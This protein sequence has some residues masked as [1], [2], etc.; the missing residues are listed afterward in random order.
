MNDAELLSEFAEQN[1]QSAFRTLMER[2]LPLVYGTARRVLGN[3]A[4]AED[5]AQTVFL[6]LARKA[7]A[8]LKLTGWL[9]N[10]TRFV[11]ARALRG[12]LRRTR[13]EQQA[14]TMNDPE[15]TWQHVVPKLDDALASLNETDRS[16]I[17]FRFFEQRGLREV[18]EAL[19]V[20]E[21]AAKKRVARALERLRRILVRRG[22][23][24]SAGALVAG[25]TY[26]ASALSFELASNLTAATLAK[27]GTA[28]ATGL[29]AEILAAITWA[30][31]KL[32]G[33]AVLGVAVIGVLIPVVR[34]QIVSTEN[35]TV[36]TPP[37]T[38]AAQTKATLLETIQV[39]GQ[40][41][42]VRGIRLTVLDGDTDRPIAGA[43][44]H[45]TFM[46]LGKDGTASSLLTDAS[47]AA[48]L[49]VPE[50]L[51]GDLPQQQFQA[52]IRA[53]N[54][55]PRAVMWLSSTGGVLA[56]VTNDCTVKL[57]RGITLAGTVVDDSGKP[58]SGILVGTI[59]SDYTGFTTRH[60]GDGKIV[61][62]PEF[63]IEEFNTYG[64]APTA[65]GP[66]AIIT[67]YE[68]RF[69]LPHYPAELKSLQLEFVLPEG[70]RRKFRSVG[71]RSLSTE[72]LPE[73]SI[74]DLKN[75][76]ARIVIEPGVVLEGVVVDANGKP[77]PGA[78]VSEAVVIGNVR[79][80]SR[81][82]TDA[83]GQFRLENRAP[84]EVILSATAAGHAGVSQ[85]IDIHPDMKPV[86]LQLSRERPLRGKVVDDFGQPVAKASVTLIDYRNDG[87]GLQWSAATDGE[88]R[89][90]W[91]DAP[92][93][94]VPVSVNATGFSMRMARLQ[95]SIGEN[96]VSLTFGALESLRIT[97][98]V[99]DSANGKP[100]QP[101]TVKVHSG[102]RGSLPE[103]LRHTVEGNNGIFEAIVPVSAFGG[104]H[105]A[106]VLQILGDG[107][108]PLLTPLQYVGEGDKHLELQL[109][110]GGIV[111]GLVVAPNG[112]PAADAVFAIQQEGNTVSVYN[113]AHLHPQLPERSEAAGAFRITKP[114]KAKT[115]I[116]S[117]DTGWASA[118]LEP[119]RQ[120]LRLQLQPWASVEGILMR[121]G[122][123]QP[124]ERISLQSLGMLAND[125][126]QVLYSATTDSE[127][128][129]NFKRMPAGEF[130][131]S[132]QPNQWQIQ[133]MPSL[134]TLEQNVVLASGDAKTVVLGETGLAV[135]ARLQLPSSSGS[136]VSTNLL[137]L[138][139]QGLPTPPSPNPARYATHAS[140]NEAT[141][142]HHR[143]PAVLAAQR[144]RRHYLGSVRPDG[145]VV[146]E[147][148]PPGRYT[149]E[150]KLFDFTSGKR[151]SSRDVPLAAQLRTAVTI[152]AE[153]E[154]MVELGSF[155]LNPAN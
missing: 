23:D 154:S 117:H 91:R 34:D 28:E 83:L 50:Y 24:V 86:R 61:S 17:L 70:S 81:N 79:V 43:Q 65:I 2:H 3:G 77:V 103:Y 63:R 71:G 92:T 124:K 108:E 82:R 30:K 76:T 6:L 133:D 153:S 74:A 89:F 119:G 7:R 18:G 1:S 132:Y 134:D 38:I 32:A 125:S 21:E 90:V 53:A 51:P 112:S 19:G 128:R 72:E 141:R 121:G 152:P 101:F 111:Q 123:P 47:G 150:A 36:Q 52:S 69:E 25:L 57:Q 78:E 104:M 14:A 46:A 120:E 42:P 95:S 107:Y 144:S 11:A 75:G 140:L 26:E 33:A 129:F 126:L 10:T 93:N 147:D 137:A 62:P 85:L 45:H 44:V 102:T 105:G 54:Y 41:I 96:I 151:H 110:R 66:D 37:Q 64:A 31:I 56:I 131:L 4:Q 155:V 80:L 136:N 135:R 60:D 27:I 118:R 130:R 29:V 100:I 68:G 97:G 106:W 109:H 116:A 113:D 114:L 49:R 35:T 148:I 48:E 67:D 149:L 98:H 99:T 22:I 15:P 84:R 139:S 115:L 5:V 87:I 88:G 94:E 55:A 39:G 59:G 16:A 143:D 40:R 145:T 9:Y 146:F 138:L 73:F 58:L 12:E 8:D 13:R 122:Q 20:T 142:N 127:G